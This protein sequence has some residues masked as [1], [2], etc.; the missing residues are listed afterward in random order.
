ML[1]IRK[2]TREQI[3]AATDWQVWQH[4]GQ[5]P[6]EYQY[7]QSVRFLVMEGAALIEVVGDKSYSIS[8]G[9]LVTVAKGVE[10]KWDITAPIT[11]RFTYELNDS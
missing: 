2:P 8:Q 10:A 6:F 1:T 7:E 11:N 4:D 5:E 3:T 9:D